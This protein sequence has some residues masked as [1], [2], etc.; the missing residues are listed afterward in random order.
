MVVVVVSVVPVVPVV[1][2]ADDESAASSDV[3]ELVHAA[4]ARATA[5]QLKIVRFII[6]E[7]VSSFCYSSDRGQPLVYLTFSRIIVMLID[8]IRW[9]GEKYDGVRF[10]WNPLKR[11]LYLCCEIYSLPLSFC[12]LLNFLFYF[13]L[14]YF[15]LFYFIPL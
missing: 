6:V 3:P 1:V 11:K 9:L 4:N 7:F 8:V 2:V 10:I 5:Q 15:I 12:I 13:I 14:F